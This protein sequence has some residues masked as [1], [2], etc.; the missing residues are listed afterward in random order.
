MAKRRIRRPLERQAGERGRQS[1]AG[2][3]SHPAMSQRWALLRELNATAGNRAVHRMLMSGK[4]GMIRRGGV[5]EQPAPG[6]G[7]KDYGEHRSKGFS[8]LERI[9]IDDVMSNPLVSL[10]FSTYGSIP[11]VIL[12]R[13]EEIG[14]ASGQYSPGKN[15]IGIT[16]KSYEEQPGDDIDPKTEAELEK[17]HEAAF[18]GT[19]LHEIFHYVEDNTKDLK[20]NIPLPTHLMGTMVAPEANGFDAYAFGWFLHPRTNEYLHFSVPG[21]MVPGHFRNIMDFPELE[22][23]Y[24]A[25]EWEKSPMPVSG[26]SISP[27]EDLAESF[28]LLL[29]SEE[30]REAFFQAY[31]LRSKLLGAYL[32]HLA[33]LKAAAD[34]AAPKAE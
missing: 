25:R 27:E 13:V 34:R 3:G 26:H 23:V 19:L 1:P 7:G 4:G 11:P 33:G 5:L 29:L 9:W 32:K 31:P 12:H 21:I 10:I 15:E 16:D 18:K 6:E 22:A 28:S 20:T 14:N 2:S 8:E 30:T 17:R 24:N